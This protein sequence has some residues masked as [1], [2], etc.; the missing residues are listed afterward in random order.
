[1]TDYI[2]LK[3]NALEKYFGNM[4]DMQ[5]K[6]VFAVNG[7]VLILAGAGSGKTT[8]LINRIVNMINFGN[9]Y[10]DESIPV[11][12]SD[13]DI[14]FLGNYNG[15][16][17]PDSVS[18]LRD[19]IAVDPV[20]PYNILAITFTNKAAGELKKRLADKL[21]EEDAAKVTAATFH[22]ACVRILRREIQNLGFT[23]S[24]AIY[25]ADDSQSMIKTCIDV[26]DISDKNFPP[27]AVLKMI[28]SAKDKLVSPDEFEASADG[29]YRKL[30]VAKIYKEYQIRMKAA[31]ALDFDDIIVF[32]VRLFEQFPD[33]L[34]HYRNLYKYVMVDE[35]QDTNFA[36]FRLVS[37]LTGKRRNLCVVGDDDQS[38]YR[39][40]GADIKNIL[41]FE[42]TFPDCS[43]IRLEQN[44]RSTSN[45]L[46]AANCVVKNN[47]SRKE[48][49]LWTNLGEGEKVVVYKA[50]DENA[51]SR[52]IADKIEKCV[53]KDNASYNDFAVLYRMNAQS[54]SLERAFTARGIPYRVLG[55]MKFYDRK[56]IKDIIAYLSVINNPDDVLRFKRIVNEP[57]RGIGDTTISMIEQIAS[58]LEVPP[59]SVMRDA[60]NLA[61]LS[62]KANSLIKAASVFDMLTEAAETKPLDELIDLLLDKTGYEN[63]LKNLG[64]E[65]TA[66]LE[67]VNEFKSTI[68]DYMKKCA[69]NGEEPSL[70][71]FLED[72][73]LYTDADKLDPDADAVAMMTVHSAKGLEF[74]TVFIAGMEEGIFPGI[75]SMD[76]TED[77]EEERRL[78]YVAVTR[79]K[80]KLY[81]TH[82]QTRMLFGQTNRN[83]Q[84]RFI[85]E[86]DKEY[87]EK[88]DGTVKTPKKKNDAGI[89]AQNNSY[90]LQSKITAMKLEAAKK[91]T[92]V[93]YEIGERIRSSN[94]GDGTVISVKKMGG[95]SLLE[96]VFDESGTKKIMANYAKI[97]KIEN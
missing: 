12:L 50:P 78:A 16:S 41:S 89:I 63:M 17:D 6:A 23:A 93:S 57:K 40:R 30:T 61:P 58:D 4:N 7:A 53:N 80:R 96:V 60:E 84:S 33:I 82:A 88:L 37:L 76:N 94:F 15:E 25:D 92:V 87:I 66:R 48:K 72:I 83:L 90:T 64:D 24:F 28:S 85:K 21:P 18:A 14:A 11:S 10:A 70:S 44:Y 65:G 69:E 27:K 26:L 67:N 68:S 73:A 38:I 45:I 3:Q 20:K 62:K 13:S 31:N 36:Q 52:F 91:N 77:L 42:N 39:F 43:V 75:R 59:V 51:E 74:D 79:A 47:R 46:G 54:N 97:T 34:N 9:A 2:K 81:I 22:S 29:D 56:E 71:G 5:K 32:T 19:I 86:I 55:G 8:V 49:K 35:Y 95:D 1:M